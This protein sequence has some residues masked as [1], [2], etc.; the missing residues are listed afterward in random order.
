[1]AYAISTAEALKIIDEHDAGTLP[2][3]E[4]THEAHLMVGLFVVLNYNKQA[5][6]EMKKRV[7]NYNELKG[8]GNDGTGYH[9]TLTVFWIWAIQKFTLENN[10]TTFDEEALDK[11]IFD[12]EL[13]RRN[14]VEDYYDE[15]L[16]LLSRREYFLSD[17]NPMPNVEYFE[18]PP[19]VV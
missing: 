19:F 14:S 8:K 5:V 6:L 4:W 7:W 9:H 13:S 17:L 12:E 1:M 11:L 16:L 3:D 2:R 18:I 15:V 10:I